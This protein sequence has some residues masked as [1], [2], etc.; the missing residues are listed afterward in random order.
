VRA[1]ED[2]EQPHG[3]HDSLPT[4]AVGAIGVVFGDIGTSPL[5]ALKESF[6]GHHPLT[7]DRAH[8]FGVLSLIF[9]TMM[10][11]VT[12]KYVFVILRA[13]NKGEGGSLALLALINRKLG[14]NRWSAGIAMLG[15]IATAL[16][17]GDAIITPAISVLSAVEGLTIVQDGLTPLVL[18]IT[19]VILIGLFAIQARGTASVG[20]LFGPVMLVYFAVLAVLGVVG[21]ARAPEI[22]WALNPWYALDFF[23]IDPK[24]AFLALG[25]VVLAVTGAEALYADMGHFGRKAI[26]ISWL[27]AAFPCLMLNYLG[28]S[29]LLLHNPAAV[30][31][32][33]FLMAPDWARLPL[34]ILATVATVIASQAVISGAF[35]VTQQ[36]V[37]LGFL[38]RLKI[39]HTSAR[40]AGQ[41]YVPLVN[42]GLLVLVILLA[43]GFKSSGNLAAAYGIA[44]TGTM[45]ITACMLGVL[46]FA[47][48]KWPPVV[49]G[50]VTGAFLLID[51]LYFASNMTKIPDGGWFPLL[52][53]AIAFTLLTT[54]ATGRRL[55]R[56]RLHEGAIPVEMFIQSAG[57]SVQRVSGTA[58]FLASRTDDIPPSL[59][60]NLKHNR[61]LHER[62][63]VLT[64][65]IEQVPHVSSTR[66]TVTDLGH[67]FYRIVL[68][69][70]F[71]EEIDI[72]AELA[73]VTNAGTPFKTMDTSYFLARQTLIASRRPGMAIW[74]EKLFAWMVRNAESAMEF[75]KLPTNRVVELGSQLEI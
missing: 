65:A 36:A 20:K 67:G 69:Y 19:I 16:F 71:M 31:N 2:P 63:V 59:L 12:V 66:A 28:Q 54:W 11:V 62:V 7:V 5:Y 22:I 17:Y 29:A 64:V 18:P 58:V 23:L 42:W 74:R 14:Q 50:I 75:F 4:L 10:L 44:V 72:P 26:S 56:E 24:L 15:V 39:L 53:A 73:K 68:R 1:M 43:L 13:D 55:V 21:I 40:A 33:F 45:F 37:Q 27:Y 70:G 30:E 38:P 34:V 9:W 25:S 57:Q 8:I 6:I 51:G 35:S 52:V 47:V 48:W 41:I 46:T 60:H 32:P 49:A 61:V 3:H